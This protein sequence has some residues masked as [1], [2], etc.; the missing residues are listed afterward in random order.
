MILFSKAIRDILLLA[1]R[2]AFCWT[3]EWYEMNY[4]SIVEFEKETYAK[5]N[6]KVLK[7]SSQLENGNSKNTDQ[8]DGGSSVAPPSTL[9][10]LS[11][12]FSSNSEKKNVEDF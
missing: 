4:E 2:Q 5:T 9:S 10:R 12:Y 11:G 7:S 8:T 6:E 3:D 1:H